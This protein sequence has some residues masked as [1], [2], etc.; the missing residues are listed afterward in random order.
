M[1]VGVD[2]LAMCKGN[3]KM[4]LNG[5]S[6]GRILLMVTVTVADDEPSPGSGVP[7]ENHVW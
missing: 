6:P 5:S 3:I 1:G 2:S 7:K 4:I